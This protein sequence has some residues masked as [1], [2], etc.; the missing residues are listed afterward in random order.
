LYQVQK[1]RNRHLADVRIIKQLPAVQSIDHIQV[2]A[3]A[4]LIASKV[5]AYHH[6][7]GKP[8]SGTDW[9][10]VAM[11]L[12]AFPEFKTPTG[13]VFDRLHS[14]SDDPGVLKVWRDLVSQNI[15]S[16]DDDEDW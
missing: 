4:D 11:L 3:P 6:R 9:R 5:I 13:D 15:E 1:P 16:P 10:D 7:R 12:L 2:M 14:L 8:K